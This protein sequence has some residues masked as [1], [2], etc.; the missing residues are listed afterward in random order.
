[1]NPT[2]EDIL[3]AVAALPAVYGLVCWFRRSA[4]AQRTANRLKQ[5]H[6]AQWNDL[7]WL[8]RRN[9]WAA[10]EALIAKGLLSG[11]IVDQFRARDEYLEKA[12]WLGLLVSAL[13]LL[14]LF[15]GKFVLATFG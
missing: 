5:T 14:V 9:S 10:I 3:A 15:V 6:G 11:P 2:V 4:N 7:P 8:T 1:M 13:L 12:T